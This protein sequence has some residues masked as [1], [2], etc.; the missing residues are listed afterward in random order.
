MSLY[1]TLSDGEVETLVPPLEEGVQKMRR[2]GAAGWLP[3]RGFERI[4]FLIV[5]ALV[6]GLKVLAIYHFRTDSDETQHA[7]VVW[8]WATGQLQYRDFFDN[9]MPLFQMACA[10]L[11]RLLGERPDI[12]IML[13][14]AMLP[15][16][17]VA[18]WAVYRLAAILYSRRAAPWATLLAAG[19]PLF[20]YTSTEFRTDDLWAVFW[21]VGLMIAVDGEFSVVRAAAFG[22]VL[23]LAFAVSLKTVVL[24]AALGTAL[25]IAMSFAWARREGPG[26]GQVLTR[27]PAILIAAIIPPAATPLYFKAQGAYWIMYYCVV[28]HNILPRLKR[29]GHFAA[30]QWYFPAAVVLLA[31]YAWLIFR[32]ERD[33]RVAIRRT[34][35]AL[36][37]WLFL[38]LLR[39]YWP[40]IT[41]EDDLPYTPLL[42][43][44]LI[45]LV[46]LGSQFVRNESWRRR[47]WTYA[48][49]AVALCEFAYTFKIQNLLEDRMRVTTH[50]I[51]DV[52]ALTK[53]DDYVMDDKGDYVFRNRAYYWVLEP[54]TKAR[55]RLGLIHDSIP[56]RLI[57]R[58][59][60]VTYLHCA[61]D[62]S[63]AA[64][65]IVANYVPF[66]IES[67]DIGV[68]GKE[69]GNAEGNGTY[70][71][72]VVIPQ[73]YAIV[74]EQG[75]AA[76][77]LDG[78]PY[79]G[80]TWLA[81]GRHTFH[82]TGGIGRTG[83]LLA[84]A[85]AHGFAFRFDAAEYIAKMVG[86][87]PLERQKK[88]PELQ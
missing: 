29:W 69:I 56:A 39:S 25:L 10:P 75:T 21:L 16:Y 27:V 53:P 24:V 35:I 15:L 40:D 9:H 1:R 11:M 78:K 7:H 82:R 63:I 6:L 87:L 47:F 80:A 20:F 50:N 33:T 18:L 4:C 57:Q 14:W 86:T 44:S 30:Y 65:F 88:P 67:M 41:R 54:I 76:G 46:I 84:D 52:L 55:V 79:T 45:P 71:F 37:P 42:P 59:V 32:Q 64:K 66:D 23:G 49:P 81:A 5:A 8:G 73:S 19:F 43:L 12:M 68:L 48:L 3:A 60:K 85:L 74:S 34:L 72:D 17:F 22:F 28:C 13:R 83:I 51:A 70:N 77:E 31:G 2:E 36:T 58:G 26:L 62:G 61:H 38:F